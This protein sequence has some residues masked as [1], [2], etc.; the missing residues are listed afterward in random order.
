M[1]K[2]IC[3]QVNFTNWRPGQ[4]NDVPPGEDCAEMHKDGL[5]TDN[6]C[7]MVPHSYICQK[8]VKG[9]SYKCISLTKIL[10]LTTPSCVLNNSHLLTKFV[11][12]NVVNTF[13]SVTWHVDASAHRALSNLVRAY[14][15][16]ECNRR[17]FLMLMSSIES[18]DK[19]SYNK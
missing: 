4:P 3:F 6:R 15:P 9:A 12:I 14:C 19:V 16:P 11:L 7:D 2:I 8:A 1:V 17:T 10:L 13:S 18:S 5:W